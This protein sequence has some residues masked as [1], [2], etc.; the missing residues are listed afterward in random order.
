[1]KSPRTNPNCASIRP[2]TNTSSGSSTT[3]RHTELNGKTYLFYDRRK[4]DPFWKAA[5]GLDVPVYLHLAAQTAFVYEKLYARRKY[6]VGTHSPSRGISLHPQP[7]YQASS[8]A[9]RI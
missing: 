5:M 6:L 8:T 2:T 3:L 1:M 9:S 4:C 7:P